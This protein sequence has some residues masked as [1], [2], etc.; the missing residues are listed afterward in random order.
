VVVLGVAQD[1]GYPQAG[2]E[3]ACCRAHWDGREPRHYAAS[4]ALLDRHGNR[5]WIFDATPDWKDQLELLRKANGGRPPKIA[6]IFLTH[7]HI[8]HYAGL[9]HLGREVAGAKGVPVYVLPRFKSFLEKNGPWSQLVQL[10]NVELRPLELETPQEIL[11]GVT[12]RPLEVPHRDEFSETAGFLVEGLEKKILY[13]PDIDKWEKWRQKIEDLLARVDLAY[14]DATFFAEGELPGRNMAEIP[15]P[16]VVETMERLGALPAEQR[17][18]V[19]F[20]HF[21]HTNPL[22]TSPDQRHQVRLRGYQVA[23]EGEVEN[24]GPLP[25]ASDCGGWDDAAITACLQSLGDLPPGFL[26][27]MGE[28]HG[29]DLEKTRAALGEPKTWEISEVYEEHFSGL[30]CR[31]V[32]ASWPGIE[33]EAEFQD[34]ESIRQAYVTELTRTSDALLPCGFALGQSVASYQKKLGP[35]IDELSRDGKIGYYWD[36]HL[37]IDGTW[38]V[39]HGDVELLHKNAKVTGIRWSYWSD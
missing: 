6:G 21:N 7:A 22:L 13:L 5:A 11:P 25:E 3:K 1:A 32:K 31:T 15:H 34:S 33:L 26:P 30:P 28:N 27:G 9:M 36:R 2:C 38:N 29:I 16:F 8:G 37:C 4:L 35:P 17:A 24:L 19:R 23:Q 10:K 39:W 14:L 20:L 18:K 12:V